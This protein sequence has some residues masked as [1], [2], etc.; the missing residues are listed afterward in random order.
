MDVA[1]GKLAGA[2][3]FAARVAELSGGRIRAYVESAESTATL[4]QLA[5]HAGWDQAEQAMALLESSDY[6]QLLESAHAAGTFVP[7]SMVDRLDAGDDGNA[8]PRP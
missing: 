4:H 3:A 6:R 7:G 8:T 5:E 2:N 1:D